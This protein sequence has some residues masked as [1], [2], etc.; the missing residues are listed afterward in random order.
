VLTVD[1]KLMHALIWHQS[2]GEPWSFS[3]SGERQP[4]VYRSAREAVH[5]ARTALP[6]SILI[7]VGLTGPAAH[8][9]TATAAMFTPCLNV[10]MAARQIAQ[11]VDRCK[12]VRPVR[13]DPIHCAIAAYRGSWEHPDNKFADAVQTSVAKADAPNFDMLDDSYVTSGDMTPEAAPAGQRGFTTPRNILDDQQQGW[14]SGLFP[15]LSQQF[16]RLSANKNRNGPDADR[17]QDSSEFSAHPMTP[18]LPE[19]SLFVRRLPERGRN[20]WF[21]HSSHDFACWRASDGETPGRR[22]T[23]RTMAG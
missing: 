16:G 23:D 14:S 7:R 8:P 1:P 9:T 17:L 2:G 21:E 4:Q 12:T 11:L 19:D 13:T 6:A 22:P 3:V 10:S 20:D 15:A 5:E 18:G